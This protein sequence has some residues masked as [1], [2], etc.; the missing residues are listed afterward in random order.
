MAKRRDIEIT[1][2]GPDPDPL[3]NGAEQPADEG[4]LLG[5]IFDRQREAR[6]AA[7]REDASTT[8]DTSETPVDGEALPAPNEA[9]ADA[10]TL[11]S[12]ANQPYSK[13]ARL[14]ESLQTSN[15]ASLQGSKENKSQG[16]RGGNK[17]REAVARAEELGRSNLRDIASRLP[18]DLDRWLE[19]I[20]FEYESEHGTRMPKQGLLKLAVQR[21]Y[22][23]TEILGSLPTLED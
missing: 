10:T 19:R 23:D 11:V 6:I 1:P 9:T 13:D 2:L 12:S 20:A 5:R 15:P 16:G 4:D 14:Q 8:M 22:I 17:R 18:A 7:A 21:L 3:A